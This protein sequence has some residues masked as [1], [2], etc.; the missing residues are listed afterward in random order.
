MQLKL[1]KSKHINKSEV[2]FLGVAQIE[3]TLLYNS[4]CIVICCVQHRE[5][6][7]WPQG[8]LM[9]WGPSSNLLHQVQTDVM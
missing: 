3:A 4:Y 6:R 5:A 9:V 1:T 8:D 2:L 7:L